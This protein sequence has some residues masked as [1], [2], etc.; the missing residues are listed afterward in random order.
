MATTTISAVAPLYTSFEI[1]MTGRRRAEVKSVKGIGTSRISPWLGMIPVRII[2]RVVP[3]IQA[4]LGSLDQIGAIIVRRGQ[5]HH[6]NAS[7]GRHWHGQ[8]HTAGGSDLCIEFV[9]LL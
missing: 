2:L 8:F 5:Y 7:A 1:T 6:L 9:C 4:A 3:E